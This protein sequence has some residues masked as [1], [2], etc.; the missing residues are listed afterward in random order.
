M[1]VKELILVRHGEPKC[2]RGIFYGRTDVDLSEK[3][4]EQSLSQVKKIANL[5]VTKVYSSPLKRCLFAAKELLKIKK[6][7]L[8]ISPLLVELDFGDWSG[9]SWEEL[10]KLNEFWKI[11]EDESFSPPGGESLSDMRKR[12]KKFLEEF[13]LTSSGIYVVFTHSG[14]IRMFFLELLSLP[15]SYF[16]KVEVDYMHIFK[17]H[18]YQDGIVTLKSWNSPLP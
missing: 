8:E 14:V 10:S 16:F 3:G 9:K 15:I 18:F 6:V 5:S 1:E 17:F 12:V 4:V 11:Y 2:G 13:S 7:P